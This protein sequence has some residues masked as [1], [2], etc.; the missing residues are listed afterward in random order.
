[1]FSVGWMDY[2]LYDWKTQVGATTRIYLN[3]CF[4]LIFWGGGGFIE[5]R[6]TFRHVISSK[7]SRGPY[8]DYCVSTKEADGKCRMNDEYDSQRVSIR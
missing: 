1:M 7:Y 5:G 2:E 4:I 6:R 3:F 8:H